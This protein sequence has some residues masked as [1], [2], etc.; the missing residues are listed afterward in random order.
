[1]LLGLLLPRLE[2]G[3]VAL[4]PLRRC[5]A[6]V[7]LGAGFAGA[8]ASTGAPGRSR[9]AADAE[10][11]RRGRLLA[12]RLERS[13][14]A[15]RRCRRGARLPV[16]AR[17]A[18]RRPP[19]RRARRCA[20]P[21]ARAASPRRARAGARA[22]HRARAGARTLASSTHD[23]TTKRSRHSRVARRVARL[24]RGALLGDPMA[25]GVVGGG[26]ARRRRDGERPGQQERSGRAASRATESRKAVHVSDV[27]TLRRASARK[28]AERISRSRET[29]RGNSCTSGPSVYNASGSTS[30][31]M[32]SLTRRS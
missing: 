28:S 14:L 16:P 10:A 1:M 25:L 17:A 19:W 29:V 8:A 18:R 2:A 13:R 12:P 4:F 15:R 5:S 20:P 30:A 24:D 26:R 31:D 3:A 11:A 27:S 22:G 7:S 9:P 32:M 6:A 21:C 23:V